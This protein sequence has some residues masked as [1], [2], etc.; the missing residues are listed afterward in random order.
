MSVAHEK[1][2]PVGGP[3]ARYDRRRF[4]EAQQPLDRREGG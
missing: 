4:R 2:V 3:A 1:Q